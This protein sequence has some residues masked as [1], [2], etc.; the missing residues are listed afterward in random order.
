MAS[1]V[2]NLKQQ[3]F[4]LSQKAWTGTQKTSAVDYLLVGGGGAGGQ[5]GGGGGAG[6][7]LTGSVPVSIGTPITVTV[8]GGGSSAPYGS[9]PSITSGNPSVFGNTVA[10]GGGRGGVESNDSPTGYPGGNAVGTPGGSGGGNGYG[11]NSGLGYGAAGQG[12][13]GGYAYGPGSDTTAGGG[14][15][16]SPGQDGTQPGA[17]PGYNHSGAGGSGVSSIISGTMTTY[18]GGGGGGINGAAPSVG[19]GG[20][21][22]GGSGGGG[23][24]GN[25]VAGTANLGGGGGGAEGGSYLSGS[26]G[27][28]VAIISYPD[29]Y[30]NAV[31]TLNGTFSTSGSGSL[32]YNG[33]TQFLS[34]VTNT[35]SF[36]FGTGDFT[37]ETWVYLNNT[38]GTQIIYDSRASGTSDTT[39]TLYLASGSIT[40]Y[41]GGSDRIFGGALSTGIWYHVALVKISG[42]T[43]LYLNGSQTG[44]TYADSNT[45]INSAGRPTIGAMS[46]TLGNSPVNG[47]LSNVRVVKGVGVYTG[48]FT[49]SIIPLSITQPAGTNIAA[50]TGTSTSLLLN[51]VSGAYLADSSTLADT[52]TTTAA[53][54]WNQLSPFATG[55]GYKNRVYTWTSS[56]TIT[57]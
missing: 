5:N 42:S 12:F 36:E 34:T 54:T 28:G 16:G 19:H 53:P 29:I 2:F 44:S 35:A 21:G 39:P 27:S 25:A 14:G 7:F 37:V 31:S 10:F 38:T 32:S 48:T 41:S 15:A 23:T 22:G 30:A 47:Y 33:S 18:A 4:G 51:C 55:L 50:I 49:P 3:L 26:G 52:F 43:K 40:Y 57:F 20:S 8:G 46:F 56:G 11:N 13:P 6:G 1:G 9:R 24:V 45:Y 17:G